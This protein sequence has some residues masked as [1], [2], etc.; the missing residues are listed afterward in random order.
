[1]RRRLLVSGLCALVLCGAP[2]S[3]WCESTAVDVQQAFEELHAWMGSDANAAHWR[4]FLRSDELERELAKGHAAD[5]ETLKQI[6]AIYSG[7]ESGLEL[8]RF[9]AV[10]KALQA[11]LAEFEQPITDLPAA[12]RAAKEK[13]RPI[14]SGRVARTRSALENA[15]SQLDGWLQGQGEETASTWKKLLDW[16]GLRR[17]LAKPKGAGPDELERIAVLYK[18]D[19]A[20]L[21]EG[22]FL[23]VR[24]ALQEHATALRFSANS[25]LQELFSER[26]ED[27]AKRLEALAKAP[28]SE[29]LT[30]AGRNL[31]WLERAG[32]SPGIVAAIRARF[33]R[34]NLFASASRR[35]VEAGFDDPEAKAKLNEPRGML[36][37][38]LGTTM[39]GTVYPNLQMSVLLVPNDEQAMINV[40]LQGGATS[41]AVGSRGPV[42]VWTSG[43]TQIATSKHIFFDANGILTSGT[44]AWCSTSSNIDSIAARCGLIER[45]AWKKA[46]QQ[47]GQ[48]EAVAS[49]RA[50]ARIAGQVDAEMGTRL[51]DANQ[52]Y[53]DKFRNRLVRRDSFPEVLKMSST[54]EAVLVHVRHAKNNQ[55]ATATEP[56]VIS[57]NH[58]LSI[59]VHESAV[60]NFGESLIGGETLTD[61]RLVEILEESKAEVPEELKVTPDKDPWS[62]TFSSEH[63]VSAKFADNGV[64]LAIRGRRFTRGDQVV[65]EEIEI[66]ANYKLE[67][68]GTGSKLTRLGEV[69]VEYVNRKQLSVGQVAMKT[70]F[71]KKFDALFKPDITSDGLKL[72]DRFKGIGKLQLRQLSSD[73]AWLV[74]GW[75]QPSDSAAVELAA[76]P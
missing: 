15:V 35:L 17:A 40:Q 71:R 32:Q 37:N 16:D 68:A 20:G 43:Y 38:I 72:P 12:V 21:E 60:I 29:D 63:P 10:R 27:L 58:D 75:E 31:G 48:A 69:R 25:K 2:A 18:S 6:V 4:A 51:A 52:S 56:P 61:E 34:P 64:K 55:L 57:G 66:S 67:K 62:I 54:E 49:A 5:P 19:E 73:Q 22:V 46:G 70:F 23:A 76:N 8:R 59:R 14:E 33:Q 74:L 53:F 9:A 30:A 7:R 50:E 26:L 24:D 65:R 39:R 11:W 3:A 47:K 42:T 13:Y 28:N 41:Q 36:E 1:M 45:I 44:S